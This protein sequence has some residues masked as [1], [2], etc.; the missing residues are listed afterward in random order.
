MKI[1]KLKTI[2]LKNESEDNYSDLEIFVKRKPRKTKEKDIKFII[3]LNNKIIN[4]KINKNNK[5]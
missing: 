2:I 4:K 5:N 1:L 3:K